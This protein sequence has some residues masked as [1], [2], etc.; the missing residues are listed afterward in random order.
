LHERAVASGI[1]R[2][3]SAARFIIIEP[4]R[5]R[6]GK[7]IGRGSSSVVSAAT[8]YGEPVAVKQM[9]VRNPTY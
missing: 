9:E 3:S 8:L 1:S 5:L 4:S 7:P 6:W 2:G